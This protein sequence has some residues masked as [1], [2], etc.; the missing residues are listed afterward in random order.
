MCD[1]VHKLLKNKTGTIL[2]QKHLDVWNK[3]V[4]FAAV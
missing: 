1:L 4:T 2:F 3:N